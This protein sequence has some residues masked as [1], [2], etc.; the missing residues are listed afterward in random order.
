MALG[1]NNHQ[2]MH[3]DVPS[4]NH[5]N[6]KWEDLS[7]GIICSDWL[8][9]IWLGTNKNIMPLDANSWLFS[10]S[11]CWYILTEFL[12][13][14]KSWSGWCVLKAIAKFCASTKKLRILCLHWMYCCEALNGRLSSSYTHNPLQLGQYPCGSG[15]CYIW[16]HRFFS[17]NNKCWKT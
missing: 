13:A 1:P 11:S 9:S 14:G 3:F 5:K 12:L 15:A 16:L 2:K 8:S 6:T 17:C 7:F 4:S 10:V